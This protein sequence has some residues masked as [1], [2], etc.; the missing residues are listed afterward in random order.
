MMQD[1]EAIFNH[2]QYSEAINQLKILNT[3]ETE[4]QNTLSAIFQALPGWLNDRGQQ[5]RIY[6][7]KIIALQ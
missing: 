5:N 1:S 7:A 4:S 2:L 6:Q 3:K